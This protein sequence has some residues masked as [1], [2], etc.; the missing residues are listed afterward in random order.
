MLH[1][2]S[3][4][5]IKLCSIRVN[6]GLQSY[7]ETSYS[8]GGVNQMWILKKSKDLLVYIQSGSLSYCN[9][10]NTFDFYTVYTT[11]SHSKLNDRL[12]DLVQ[13]CFIKKIYKIT[14]KKKEKKVFIFILYVC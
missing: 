4:Q 13:L 5:I 6:N 7:C 8:R 3:F 2:T 14:H 1:E 9:S 11:I 10:I 12:R